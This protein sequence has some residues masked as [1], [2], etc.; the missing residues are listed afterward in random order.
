L[1]KKSTPPKVHV[2]PHFPMLKEDNIRKGFFERDQLEEICRYLPAHLVPVA[3]LATSL[4][5]DTES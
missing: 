3:K 5:G 1:A 4:G 2:A